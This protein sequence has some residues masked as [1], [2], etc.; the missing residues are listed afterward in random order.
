MGRLAQMFPR[1]PHRCIIYT[2]QNPT[3]FESEEELKALKKV[4][5]E[6]RCRKESNTSIRTFK[7]TEN[8][9][10]G[11]Y[12]VQLGALVG[13]NLA[14]DADAA[15]D[16]RTGEECGAI[17]CDVHAGMFIDFF[18]RNNIVGFDNAVKESSSSDD[19][20]SSEEEPIPSCTLN[21]NDVYA[22]NLG[23]TLYCDEYKT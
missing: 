12:R 1:F 2:M 11:D 3:G 13:G 21:L 19:S 6:G 5:W 17:V 8:V 14:G 7:G 22:G 18:D 20:S 9:L 10:K 4:V 16:G 15:P 23:T